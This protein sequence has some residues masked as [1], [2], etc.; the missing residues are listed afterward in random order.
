MKR[1]VTGFAVAALLL[2]IAGCPNPQ[3]IA[4]LEN[5]VEAQTEKITELEGMVEAL[6]MERD[7]LQERV[8]ELE[9]KAAGKTPGKTPAKTPGGTSPGGLKPP[10]QK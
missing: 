5:Q 9:T 3:K 4:D 10:T 7:A 6:T 2:V 1:V 8:E